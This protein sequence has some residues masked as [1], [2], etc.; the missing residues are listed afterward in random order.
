MYVWLKIVCMR[1]CN[2]AYYATMPYSCGK[3]TQ[4]WLFQRK[5]QQKQHQYRTVIR[6]AIQAACLQYIFRATDKDQTARVIKRNHKH[7]N[8]YNKPA[9]HS[10]RP[11][12][13]LV[14]AAILVNFK[15][16]K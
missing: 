16:T 13:A 8:N 3:E 7:G 4:K 12:A 1:N 6:N 11:P 14:C 9:P 5:Q 10:R 2:E 15:R